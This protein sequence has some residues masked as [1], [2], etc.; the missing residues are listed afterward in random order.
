MPSKFFWS[1]T[2]IFDIHGANA[3]TRTIKLQSDGHEKTYSFDD[4]KS[5]RCK[6][7]SALE[8]VGSDATGLIQSLFI[9]QGARNRALEQSGFFIKVSD[10]QFPEWRVKFYP[11]EGWYH[12]PEGYR[13][14]EMQMDRWM[15]VFDQVVNK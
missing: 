9:N 11:T 13:N 4:I 10:I 8:M 7:P 6:L 1:K 12:E 15:E 3:N 2:E 14:M 5:W